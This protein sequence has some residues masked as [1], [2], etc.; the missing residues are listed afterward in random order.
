MYLPKIVFD[1]NEGARAY[2]RWCHRKGVD[3]PPTWALHERRVISA[4]GVQDGRRRVTP[5][6]ELGCRFAVEPEETEDATF[7]KWHKASPVLHEAMKMKIVGEYT[8]F[9]FQKT[10]FSSR[11]LKFKK[12]TKCYIRGALKICT[13]LIII[14]CSLFKK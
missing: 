6:H 4:A 5:F 7:A 2:R 14:K 12:T 9:L 1:T 13:F 10:I 11:C 3:C 8:D